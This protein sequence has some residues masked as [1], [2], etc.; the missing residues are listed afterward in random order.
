MSG[1]STVAALADA[2]LRGDRAALA[3]AITLIESSSPHH[4]EDRAELLRRV[5]PG[6]G[7]AVRVGITGV[8][9]A[10]KS[11]F[12]ERAGLLLCGAG[13][14]VAVL[15]VDPSSVRS[16]GSILGDRTRM[17]RLGAEERA[18]IRPSP[19]GGSL[20]GVTRR[21]REASMLCDGAGYGVV[22]IE[23]VGVGQSE[24]VVA[25][26]VD[27]VLALALPGAGDA[28]Q[29]VKR[30]LLEV[31]DV[32]AVN[33]GDGAMAPLARRSASELGAALRVLRP[34]DDVPVLVCSALT[35]AGVR[36]V[37]E[38]VRTRVE[39]RRADGTLDARR[40]DQDVRWMHELVWSRL[41]A[42][43]RESAR[44]ATAARDAE[45]AVRAGSATPADAADRVVLA[46]LDDIR[47]R[48]G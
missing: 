34:A 11:T 16:G 17:G 39:S 29:G 21:T 43:L 15:A 30:G 33:K 3:R 7:R 37:W 46:L 44:G 13:E 25:G 22:L 28:L 32:V 27:C 31:V 40:R 35:G 36:D 2:V 42:L 45:A 6:T 18:F 24:T 4:A 10:G 41:D 5:L 26:M 9:G 20:G 1:A 48:T 19:S 23:T 8:P 47:S 14:R 38:A 12:I